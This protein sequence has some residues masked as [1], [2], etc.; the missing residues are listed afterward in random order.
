MNPFGFALALTLLGAPSAPT[1]LAFRDFFEPTPRELRPSARLLSL[2]GQRVR[3]VGYMA[4]TEEPPTGGFY[5]CPSPVLVTE[6]G[7]GTADL[8]PQTV[9]VVVR[10]ARGRALEHRPGP[11]VVTGVLELGGAPDDADRVFPI[12][13]H[14]DPPTST[15]GAAGPGEPATAQP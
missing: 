3:I 2:D 15:D 9:F 5:L 12:R 10:S 6:S 14:F 1:D 13:I 11:L 4:R 7:A 8:P